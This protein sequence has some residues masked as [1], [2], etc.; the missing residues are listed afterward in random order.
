[1][2]NSLLAGFAMLAFL[3]VGAAPTA[4]S[5]Y[6]HAHRGGDLEN[7]APSAPENS[8]AAFEAS[9]EHGFV[10]ELDVKLTS[11]NVPVV[12]HDGTLDRTTTC[13]GPVADKSLAELAECR[14]D[15]T[16]SEDNSK[17]LTSKDPAKTLIPTLSQVLVLI[18]KSGVTANI[19]S[20]TCRPTRTSTRLTPTRTRSR[21]RSRTL[22]SRLP[23]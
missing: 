17:P 19:G 10:L 9:A 6:I 18:R 22:A 14:I 4:A 13:S 3:I 23:R 5:P 15:V 20:R 12:I 11:D 1:M 21:K 7:G 8:M 16:G 2:R